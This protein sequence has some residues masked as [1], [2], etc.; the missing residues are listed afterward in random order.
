MS[1]KTRPPE[2]FAVGR[3]RGIVTRRRRSAQHDKEVWDAIVIVAY[4]FSPRTLRAYAD[5]INDLGLRS[6]NGKKW[7][8]Q[9]LSHVFKRHGTTAKKL[10][11]AAH[12]PSPY[13]APQPAPEAKLREY[14]RAIERYESLNELNGVWLSATEAA[15]SKA[16]IVRHSKFGQGQFVREKGLGRLLCRF[17][18]YEEGTFETV[19]CAYQT[20]VFRHK[21][22]RE[23]RQLLEER[24]AEKWLRPSLE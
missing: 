10:T 1:K 15:P 22:T 14:R 5:E 18:D 2:N 11:L 20:E 24:L 6:P 7:T 23:E 9:K 17:M 12:A 8:A 21:R 13:Q 16:D 3:E 19:V 4:Y